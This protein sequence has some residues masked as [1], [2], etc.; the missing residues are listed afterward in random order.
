MS[1]DQFGFPT[2]ETFVALLE[3]VEK[4]KLE[5][6]CIGRILTQ[7]ICQALISS[8]P[9]M[10][11][12]TL[13][14]DLDGNL[15]HLKSALIGAVKRNASLLTVAGD[16]LYDHHL[17]DENDKRKLNCYAARNKGIAQL[18]AC[19]ATVPRVAWAKALEKAQVTGPDTVFRIVQAIGTFLGPFDGERCQ[20]RRRLN[21]PS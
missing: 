2:R 7:P 11:V 18:I 4:S 20:K 19:P 17:F 21:P 16:V 8:I 12:R 9:K 3:A 13:K 5:D 14:F 1:L 10:Q 15:R 6:F